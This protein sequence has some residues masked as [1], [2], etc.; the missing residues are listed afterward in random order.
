M[1]DQQAGFFIKAILQYQ[2]IGTLPELDFAMEM[3][4][5]HFI[6]QFTRDNNKYLK[7]CDKNKNN[8]KETTD[9]TDNN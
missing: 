7:I 9:K 6:N 1:T 5:T 3:A 2:D 8:G 4:I